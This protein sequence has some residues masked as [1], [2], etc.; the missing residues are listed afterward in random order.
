MGLTAPHIPPAVFNSLHSFTR[1]ARF[2]QYMKLGSSQFI[3]SVIHSLIQLIAELG[4]VIC[5]KKL[6]TSITKSKKATF[7]LAFEM[8][9]CIVFHS[10]RL[11]E[12]NKD[13]QPRTRITCIRDPP[14]SVRV[15]L[16]TLIVSTNGTYR[17]NSS[18]Y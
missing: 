1:F 14:L 3:H 7:K 13:G 2:C 5:N 8:D 16:A 10:S 17:H 12:I 4:G 9:L 18:R 11:N 6:L 15:V